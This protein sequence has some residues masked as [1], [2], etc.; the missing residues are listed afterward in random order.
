MLS[1]VPLAL[2]ACVHV[3][4]LSRS[5][6]TVLG[7]RAHLRLHCQVASMLEV[8]PGLDADGDGV[9]TPAE[10]E[11]R[12]DDVADYVGRHYRLTAGS[13]RAWQDGHA[14]T[15]R[16]P[17]VQPGDPDL[18]AP[19][20]LRDW[21]DVELQFDD[22]SPIGD[23]LVDVSLFRDTSPDHIDVCTA[24]FAGH[25]PITVALGPSVPRQRIDPSGA[26]ALRWYA[27]LGLRHGLTGW[28]H[29]AVALA[30]CLAAR[31]RRGLL[32]LVAVLLAGHAAGT[33]FAYAGPL[34]LSDRASLFE[35][36]FVLAIA[37]VA[38]D[39]LLEPRARQARPVEVFLLGLAHGLALFGW[40]G[41]ALAA[42]AAPIR[43][44]AGFHVGLG[45][46]AAASAA[47][48]G[49]LLGRRL[50]WRGDP[51]SRRVHRL[52][53]GALLVAGLSGFVLRVL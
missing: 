49:T 51:P 53:A 4:S 26:G 1:L 10:L 12:R 24:S 32:G 30:L 29:W 27:R 11:A 50:G 25:E 16:A 33:A 37:Y 38:A 39:A 43:A 42:E 28:E 15:P 22:S 17:S 5:E 13:D 34:D 7:S 23:L 31:S 8:V 20:W 46:A 48:A 21:I 3:N 6:I 9:V 47:A 41:P 2:V 36:A 45:V 52:L 19:P 35:A 40:L 18:E 44:L 14:L